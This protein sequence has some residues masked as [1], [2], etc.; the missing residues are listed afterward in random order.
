VGAHSSEKLKILHEQLRLIKT[1]QFPEKGVLDK[2]TLI[3]PTRKKTVFGGKGCIDLQKRMVTVKNIREKTRLMTAFQ[4]ALH[5][6]NERFWRKHISMQK[7]NTVA[8]GTACALIHLGRPTLLC[9]VENLTLSPY[10]K[11]F[12]TVMGIWGERH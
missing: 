5:I 2:K 11:G 12:G 1:T 10:G 9:A 8:L 7:N 4:G 3:S 6:V